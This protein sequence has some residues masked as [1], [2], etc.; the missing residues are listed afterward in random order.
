ML[1]QFAVPVSASDGMCFALFRLEFVHRVQPLPRVTLKQFYISLP[2]G[3]LG[4]TEN[5]SSSA[6]QHIRHF[7]IIVV[8]VP[9]VMANFPATQSAQFDAIVA[10]EKKYQ[11]R[12]ASGSVCML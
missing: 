4:K 12:V 3:P 8:L 1:C 9:A 5:A 6:M 10:K 11:G 7:S 2:F